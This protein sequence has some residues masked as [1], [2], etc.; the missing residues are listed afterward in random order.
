[1]VKGWQVADI[2][3]PQSAV[4][5]I[6]WFKSK[7]SAT[8][9]EVNDDFEKY[10]IS[11][12]L[13]KLYKLFWDEFSSWYLELIKPAYMQP[14]DSNTYASTLA[15]FEELTLLLHPFMP[16]ITEE[17]W[18][19]LEEPHRTCLLSEI[20]LFRQLQVISCICIRR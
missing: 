1:M 3:Q 13:M 15:F 12:A 8:I 5:A 19:A 18:H 9:E 6:E 11:E 17:I 14:I 20:Y 10:R 2:E 7:I 16:F 4:I